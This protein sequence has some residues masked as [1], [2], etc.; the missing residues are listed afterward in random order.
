MQRYARQNAVS[1]QLLTKGGYIHIPEIPVVCLGHGCGGA[2]G[3][4]GH[5]AGAGDAHRTQDLTLG[6]D[7]AA[8][9]DQVVLALWQKAP[10]GDPDDHVLALGVRLFGVAIN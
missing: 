3:L 4:A 9:C 1:P 5:E 7:T 6:A 8:C 2:G 10:V